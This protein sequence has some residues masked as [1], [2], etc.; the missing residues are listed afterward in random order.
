[1]FVLAPSLVARPNEVLANRTALD[2][3]LPAQFVEETL[4]VA[5][6]AED[7]TTLPL[8]AEGGVYTDYYPNLVSMLDTEGFEVT[9]L[10]TQ[11]IL[12]RKLMAASF[13]VFILPNQ[14]PKDEIINHVLDYWLAGGGILS[15][16]GSLGYLL[17][18]GMI[19]PSLAG[20]FGLVGF[21]PSPY[22]WANDVYDAVRV[23]ERNPVS[24]AFNVDD[25]LPYTEDATVWNRFDLQSLVGSSMHTL[26]IINSSISSGSI[27]A[28]DNPELGGRIVQIPG[29]CSSFTDW[30]RQATIDAIDWLAPRPKGRILVDLTHTPWIAP[31]SWD[32][33]VEYYPLTTWRNSL[34]NR[35]YIVDKLHTN[36]T[37]DNLELYDMILVPMPN[38]NFTSQEVEDVRI[39]VSEGGGLFVLGDE[40]YLGGIAEYSDFLIS[41]YSVSFNLTYPGGSFGTIASPAGEHPLHEGTTLM[42]YGNCANLNITGDAFPLWMDGGN[43]VAAGQ[44]YGAGRIVVSSDGNIAADTLELQQEDN[45]VY[46]MNVANW[47]TAAT[48][49]VLVY[50]DS[51]FDPRDPNLVPI[52]GPVAQA[53]ND[54]EIPFYMTS[55]SY[56]FN[57]SLFRDDWDMVIFDN[58]FYSTSLIQQHLM[59]FV[60]SGGKLIFTSWMMSS[61]VLPYFGIENVEHFYVEP[62]TLFLWETAH[63]IFNLPVD[64]D[65][66]NVNSTLDV[67]GAG[68]SYAINFTTYANAT[69]LAGFSGSPDGGAGIIISA[70]GRAIVNGPLLSLYGE[71]TDNSTYTDNVELWINQIGYLFY[72]RPT[73]NHPDDVIYMETETGNEIS[74]TPSASAGPW[75]YVFS[76]N[77]TPVQG[78][79]WTGA[80][81]TFNVDGV[82]ASIT[83]YEITVFDRLGYS[84]SDLVIL[85]VTEYVEPTTTTGST[86]TTGPGGPPLDPTLVIIIGVAGAGV[87]IILVVVM[88]LKKKK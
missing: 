29:N 22:Y 45:F 67:Y 62:R 57:V 1:M 55:N 21:G 18:M 39:W 72:D 84:V 9:A 69:T 38:A 43:I 87:V 11:D 17:F 24:K 88:Q 30:Q 47:L 63:P 16:D 4:R 58:G 73:I 83:D 71:D 79:R 68:G 42:E 35:S 77:G 76:V 70:N 41:P 36:L 82:N 15:F 74:W 66:T 65:S 59:E 14:L 54:L 19:H 37:L 20:D 32:D 48:A 31:D 44:E 28:F 6:Y 75:T 53:L 51:S 2:T 80:P 64:Y 26:A 46:L 49:K 5:V 8:Y 78:G 40:I 3:V 34:V 61:S 85:H 13:D 10:S 27:G 60:E 12:D 86:T 7:N 23:I 52:N 25:E 56:Y 50:A 81:L 33:Y